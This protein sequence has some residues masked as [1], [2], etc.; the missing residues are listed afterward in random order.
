MHQASLPAGLAAT[1]MLVYGLLVTGS[2]IP[3]G[4]PVPVHML[5]V[6]VVWAVL[7]LVAV[8]VWRR[9]TATGVRIPITLAAAGYPIQAAVGMAGFFGV[10][11]ATLHLVGGMAVF[12]LVLVALGVEVA[13]RSV[14]A[15]VP[16]GGPAARHPA[17]AAGT[18]VDRSRPDAPIGGL[19]R[20]IAYLEL[21]KPR[22]M[23]LLCL[24]ALA[25]IALAILHGATT[26]GGVVIAV[27]AGGVL[28]IGASGTFNHVLEVERDRRMART[29]NRPLVTGSIGR[30][31]AAA[32]GFI[33]AAGALTVM[34]VFVNRLTMAL[35]AVAIVYY[36]VIYT[37]I[38]KPH[39]TWNIAIGGG[40]GAMPAVIGWAGATGSVGWPALL[41][42]GLVV[43]WTPAHFYNLAI[44][45]REEYAAASF[46]MLPVVRGT[47]IARRR[48]VVLLGATLLA[49]VVLGA[50]SD[51][52]AVF[53]TA[54]VMVG[55]LFLWAV[56]REARVG[57]RSAA[58]RSFHASNAYLGSILCAIIVEAILI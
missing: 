25:G 30:G 51:L 13:E 56:L 4:L 58:Y 57:T 37:V 33:L 46:P 43:V 15:T 41:L 31:P 54:T 12:G 44:A 23:W 29:R 42:A 1:A 34:G 32:F 7:L 19:E 9:D 55:G 14:E 3:L 11:V 10:D 52:G 49:A 5:A 8:T 38:L 2:I 36:S 16:A 53:G 50:T 45:R 28:A 18:G 17:D 39:T 20:V 21:T 47:R 6:G 48:I 24:L 35:T 27:I 40:A 26:S 22:L